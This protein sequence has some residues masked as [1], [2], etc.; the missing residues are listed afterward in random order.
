MSIQNHT[1]L[2]DIVD[3][4]IGVLYDDTSDQLIANIELIVRIDRGVHAPIV[5][6]SE[7]IR[8]VRLLLEAEA[9]L[10]QELVEVEAYI[11]EDDV[12]YVSS[13]KSLG[14]LNRMLNKTAVRVVQ[15]GSSYEIVKI[16]AVM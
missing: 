11:P 9:F 8:V 10:P 1:A 5:E 13:S 15:I 14:I 12:M 3:H 2:L 7:L 6:D 4:L 16:L